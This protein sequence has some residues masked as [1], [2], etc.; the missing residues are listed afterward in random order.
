MKIDKGCYI[1]TITIFYF[2]FFIYVLFL[3]GRL[4]EIKNDS[5]KKPSI[6]ERDEF[7]KDAFNNIINDDSKCKEHLAYFKEKE[8]DETYNF[9]F[10]N[11]FAYSK[12]FYIVSLIQLFLLLVC[13]IASCGIICRGVTSESTIYFDVELIIAK[14]ICIR[15][16]ILFSSQI[17]F[18]ITFIINMIYEILLFKSYNNGKFEEFEYFRNCNF[19]DIEKFNNLYGF[20]FDIQK[21][22]KFVLISNLVFIGL[23]SFTLIFELIFCITN[24]NCNSNSE[25]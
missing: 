2:I 13:I 19:F 21:N 17:F 22:C 10:D 7:I 6:E 1:I 16:V 3:Q 25:Y 24:S 4:A 20:V 9:Q 14:Q 23:N 11:L 12:G 18:F 8:I 5:Q 15:Y